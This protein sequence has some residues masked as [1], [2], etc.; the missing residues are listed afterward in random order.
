M[1]VTYSC[2]C[3]ILPEGPRCVLIHELIIH[4]VDQYSEGPRQFEGLD[5]FLR[6]LDPVLHG[7]VLIDQ[8]WLSIRGV[9]GAGYGPLILSMSLGDVNNS[10]VNIHFSVTGT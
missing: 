5:K 1:V 9:S 3:N 4:V 10:E 2:F 7:F 6:G 8:Y